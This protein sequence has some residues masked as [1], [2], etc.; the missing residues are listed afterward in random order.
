MVIAC[1]IHTIKVSSFFL[2]K[3]RKKKEKVKPVQREAASKHVKLLLVSCPRKLIRSK[4][5][6][7]PN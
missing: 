1:S 6:K 5:P 2:L 7:A 3:K 4:Q